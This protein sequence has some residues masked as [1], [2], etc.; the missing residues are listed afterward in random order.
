MICDLFMLLIK[1]KI[2][3]RK[4]VVKIL[5][6][7]LLK[8]RIKDYYYLSKKISILF[9]PIL[10]LCQCFELGLFVYFYG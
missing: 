4:F 6:A 7:N 10:K 8:K 1:N 9:N 2:R 5:S 3:L